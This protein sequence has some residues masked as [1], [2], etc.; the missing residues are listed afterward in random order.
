MKHNFSWWAKSYSYSF[1]LFTYSMEQS[2]SWETSVLGQS[3][4]FPHLW[5]SKVHC[6]VYKIPPTV[7]SL[8]QI[9]PVLAPHPTSWRASLILSFHLRLGLPNDLCP[10]GFLT[11]ALYAPILPIRATCSTH[12]ILLDLITRMIFGEEYRSVSSSLCSFLHS[13]FL[14]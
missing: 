11:K 13:S 2:P 4:N 1:E 3:R 12:H 5:N 9:N 10:P 6:R 8:G 7:P 14:H